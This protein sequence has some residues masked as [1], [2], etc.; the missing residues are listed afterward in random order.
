LVLAVAVPSL[1]VV[2]VQ[3]PFWPAAAV[4]PPSSLVLAA[5]LPSLLGRPPRLEQEQPLPLL[6]R[7]LAL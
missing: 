1:L 3:R 6:R 7:R 4:L 2:V 5:V